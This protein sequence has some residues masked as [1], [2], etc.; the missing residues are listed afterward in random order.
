MGAFLSLVCF[1]DPAGVAGL[2][3]RVAVLFGA[4]GEVFFETTLFGKV[5]GIFA[6]FASAVWIG[7]VCVRAVHSLRT[8]QDQRGHRIGVELFEMSILVACALTLPS[9]YAVGLY[10]LCWHAFRHTIVVG[11]KLMETEGGTLGGKVAMLHLRSWP[12]SLPVLPLMLWLIWANGSLSSP[13][14]WVAAFLVVCIVFTLPHHLI[15]ERTLGN[16]THAESAFLSRRKPE[17]GE[18]RRKTSHIVER[19]ET[20]GTPIFL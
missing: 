13:I 11:R 1:A 19:E 12:L 7:F 9:V 10:F 6:L 14:D 16:E 18:V 15:V 20:S 8:P 5:S 17:G 3:G 4:E 2:F